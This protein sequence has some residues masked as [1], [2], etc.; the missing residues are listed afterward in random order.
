[1]RHKETH[2]EKKTITVIDRSY[3]T[4]DL[5]QKIIIYKAYSAEEAVVEL[6]TGERYP[7]GGGGRK[8][9]VDICRECFE[10]K[11]IPWL[12]SQGVMIQE[13]EWDY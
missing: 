8:F 10:E 1:M 12:Q 11:L 6:T 13:E 9:F 7:E 2:E 5:C 3:E 4:C